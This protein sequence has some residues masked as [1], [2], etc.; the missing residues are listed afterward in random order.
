MQKISG[1]H[2]TN[3]QRFIVKATKERVRIP[4]T[5][6]PPDLYEIPEK[7]CKISIQLKKEDF[8]CLESRQ[9][10]SDIIIDAYLKFIVNNTDK[11]FG[12]TNSYFGKILN[13]NEFDKLKRW[14]GIP[15]LLDGQYDYFF[16]PYATRAHW[17][18]FTVSWK[19]D[20][21][22]IYDSFGRRTSTVGYRL[23]KFL[24]ESTNKQF[25]TIVAECGKQQ[26]SYDCGV[27][28]LA[29]AEA[30]SNGKNPKN[31]TQTI[32]NGYRSIIRQHLRNSIK[33]FGK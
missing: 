21:I 9:W 17:I 11:N 20:L 14:E 32:V 26:N 13:K 33:M 19:E 24:K 28:L 6:S 22:Y 5:I 27:F 1:N 29:Y 30:I 2:P 10:L 25:R 3:I 31:V 23:C 8:K 15:K 18:L 12:T 16:I 4:L 7:N